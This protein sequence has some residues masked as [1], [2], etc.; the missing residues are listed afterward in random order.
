MTE[1]E[2]LGPLPPKDAVEL[3]PED[4]RD[5][6]VLPVGEEP[7]EG[8]AR[9]PR[10]R[11]AKGYASAVYEDGNT[12]LRSL[13]GDV[14]DHLITQGLAPEDARLTAY[15]DTRHLEATGHVEDSEDAADAIRAREGEPTVGKALTMA[16]NRV[17]PIGLDQG[18]EEWGR[19][20]RENEKATWGE[21]S[22]ALGK[23][24]QG[25]EITEADAKAAGIDLPL[26]QELK[27]AYVSHFGEMV[28]T[29]GSAGI[30]PTIGSITGLI[31]G[32]SDVVEQSGK[33]LEVAKEGKKYVTSEELV[34]IAA[35]GG[36]NSPIGDA[37]PYIVDA[38]VD[39]HDVVTGEDKQGR[40][41]SATGG[42]V[43]DVFWDFVS[44][45]R[46]N[47]KFDPAAKALY[48]EGDVAGLG[49]LGMVDIPEHVPAVKVDLPTLKSAVEAGGLLAEAPEA[50]RFRVGMS[51][52]LSD[53]VLQTLADAIPL[54]VVRRAQ[55]DAG[56]TLKSVLAAYTARKK[57]QE[58]VGTPEAD[59]AL[60][61]AAA[62]LHDREVREDGSVYFVPSTTQK[63]LTAINA[64]VP[65]VIEADVPVLGPVAGVYGGVLKAMGFEKLG[66]MAESARFPTAAGNESMV[67]SG[68]FDWVL[69]GMGLQ[70]STSS[71][72]R[73]DIGE[74]R[75]IDRVLA[76]MQL[77]QYQ[78]WGLKELG[79]DLGVKPGST[80]DVALGT[81]DLGA[82]TVV[83]FEEM[84]LG[85]AGSAV[86][87]ASR[88]ATAAKLSK[89]LGRSNSQ[90]ARVA[91]RAALPQFLGGSTDA[92]AAMDAALRT[93][94]ADSV[95]AGEVLFTVG[96][97]EDAVKGTLSKEVQRAVGNLLEDVGIRKEDVFRTVN[98]LSFAQKA[99][100]TV[101]VKDWMARGT[102]EQ[103]A[104]RET[105]E[106][107]AVRQG[108]EESAPPEVVDAGM[109]LNEWMAH[110][111]V[112]LGEFRSPKDW[113]AAQRV[114]KAIDGAAPPPPRPT[115]VA[116]A[117]R[118]AATDADGE[119]SAMAA[120]LLAMNHP[121]VTSAALDVGVDLGPGVHGR[122][123]IADNHIVL[124]PSATAS[125][126]VHE[127]AHAVTAH[128]LRNVDTLS[129][130]GRKAVADLQ[131]LYAKASESPDLQAVGLGLDNL[132]EFIAEAYSNPA[133]RAALRKVK[134]TPTKSAW[135]VFVDTVGQLLGLKT[136]PELD[137]LDRTLSKIEVVAKERVVP[138][139]GGGSLA[140]RAALVKDPPAPEPPDVLPERHPADT[141]ADV[142]G[143]IGWW[144]PLDEVEFRIGQMAEEH[145]IF[146][147]REGRQIA[148][149]GPEDTR[150]DAPGY[151]PATACIIYPKALDDLAAS[152][153]GVYTHNHPSGSAPSIDDVLVARR[154][155]VDAL[156]AV[157]RNDGFTWVV[158]RPE[159]GWPETDVLRRAWKD[160]AHT[161]Y[162]SAKKRMDARIK[163]AGGNLWEGDRAAGF[164]ETVWKE[165]LTNGYDTHWAE[166]F[167]DL[168]IVLERER[169]PHLGQLGLDAPVRGA[170]GA[171]GAGPAVAGATEA[172]RYPAVGVGEQGRLFSRAAPEGGTV[173]K[174][175]LGSDLPRL[176]D[177]L[178]AS[179][180][181]KPLAEV[182]VK[183]LVQN[184]FDAIKATARTDG[185]IHVT[186]NAQE[187]TLSVADNGKGMTPE[188]VQDALFTV[189][190]TNKEGLAV[191]DRSG[192]L[193]LAKMAFL[194][195]SEWVDVDTVHGGVRTRVHATSAQ[196]KASDFD[197]VTEPAPGAPNG[198]NVTLKIP[199]TYRDPA[200]GADRTIYL[201]K[202]Q[203]TSEQG[204][205]VLDRPL[206]GNVEVLFTEVPRYG[207]PSTAT[208]PVGRNTDPLAT[209]LLTRA[210]FDW[211][212]ADVYMGDARKKYPRHRVLSAG[213][214]QF[215]TA[216]LAGNERIPYDIVVD[217][218]P[219]V[220]PLHPHY[221]FNNQR[222]GW[223]G[224]VEADVKALNGYIAKHSS[225][226]A[227]AETSDVF[228][229]AVTMPRVAPDDLDV[230]AAAP[231]AVKAFAPK[232]PPSP[233]PE[234]AAAPRAPDVIKISAGAVAPSVS[235]RAAPDSFR[236]ERAAPD[237]QS[238]VGSVAVDPLKPLFHN[239]TGVDYIGAVRAALPG[240][241]PERFLA[242]MGSLVLDF[243]EA[244]AKQDK[245]GLADLVSL[246]N[247][248]AAGISIDKDY[249]GVHVK[250]PYRAFFLNPLAATN[251]TASGLAE[252]ML[253]TLVHE[254]A[255]TTVM[256]HNEN[257]ALA[258]A[259]VYDRLGDSGDTDIFRARL[260]KILTR[261]QDTFNEM[262][263]IYDSPRT[264]NLRG[265]LEN[266][267]Q[268]STRGAPG[269]GEGGPGA[270]PGDA[271]AVG[272]LDG[273]AGPA[274]RGV[275]EPSARELIEAALPGLSGHGNAARPGPLY[276]R[277]APAPSAVPKPSLPEP[278]DEVRRAHQALVVKRLLSPSAE[279]RAAHQAYQAEHPEVLAWAEYR[280]A[281]ADAEL[282]QA[283]EAARA[284][285]EAG[286]PARQAAA[287]AKAARYA[288]A[289]ATGKKLPPEERAMNRREWFG[290][291]AVTTT[292]EAGGKPLVVTHESPSKFSE[293]RAGEFGF[294]FGVGIPDGMFGSNRVSGLLRINN[295]MRMADL[296]VWTP[297]RV[298]AEG[299]FSTAEQP[300][301]LA[302]VERIRAEA[303]APTKAMVAKARASGDVA[304][305]E[306]WQALLE[307]G[308]DAATFRDRRGNYLASRPVHDA[309]REKGYDGIVY[310]NEAEGVDDS[311]IAFEPQQFKSNKNVGTYDATDPRFLYSRAAPARAAEEAAEPLP[312]FRSPAATEQRWH[313]IGD[314]HQYTELTIS[315]EGALD[316][317]LPSYAKRGRM[318]SGRGTGFASG[319]YA[320]AD[321]RQGTVPV[322]PARNPLTLRSWG[323]EVPNAAAEF[324][325]D[326]SSLLFLAE[327]LRDLSPAKR[328]EAI[329]LL[330][331]R[332]SSSFEEVYDAEK[333]LA[334]PEFGIG[335]GVFGGEPKFPSD[336]ATALDPLLSRWRRVGV[337]A[338]LD[339]AG[340]VDALIDAAATWGKHQHVHPVNILL[341][342]MGH[343]GIEWA[344]GALKE[345]NTGAHGFVKFPPITADGALV[346]V[347]PDPR[348]GY[349]VTHGGRDPRVLY[350]RA[351]PARAAEYRGVD[352]KP[353]TAT[354]FSGGGLVEAGLR[355]YI[356]PVFAVEVSPEIGAAYKAA[357]GDHVRIDDVRNV[358]LGEA[359]DVDYL[360][361]S[362]VCKN[363]SAAKAVTE[364]GE[365]PLDLETARATA[366]AVHRTQPAVFT[367]ENVR[368]YQ[369][370]EA[371]GLVEAALREEGYTFDANV[372]DA[373]DYGAATRRKRLLLRAVK[374]GDLPPVPAPTH[375]PG[376]AQ[377]YADWY[378][379]VEDLVDDLPDDVVP[380]W[381]RRR[382]EAAGIDPDAPAKPTIV[383]GGSAGKNVP[384]AEAGGP[385]PTFKATPGEAH[386]IIFPDGRVKRVTPRA[387]ARITGLP[388]DYPLPTK[389][390]TATTVIGNGVPPALSEA[391][392]APLLAGDHVP[393][394]LYS[395]AAPIE[396]AA[397]GIVALRKY[398]L[399]A[400]GDDT[401]FDAKVYA[402]RK[403]V[404]ALT[405]HCN[406]A[407]YIVQKR[408]GGELLSAKVDGETHVW[409][410]LADGTEI[411]LTG[412][413]YGGDGFHPVAKNGKV[414]PLRSTVNPRFAAFEDRVAAAELRAA[415]DPRFLY[416]R[417]PGNQTDTPAFQRF[418]EGT[419]AVDE[420]GAPK[421]LYHGT[422]HDFEAF[423]AQS[424]NV[425]NHHGRGIY[426]TSSEGD[427]GS[428]Y[429]TREGP[430]LKSR[431]E[432]QMESLLDV[433][434][435]P[436]VAQDF[437]ERWLEAHPERAAEGE[438]LVQVL[439]DGGNPDAN[440]LQEIT[441]WVAEQEIA[442]SHGGAVLPVYAAIKNPVDLRPGKVTRFDI[443]TKW[444]E[445]GEDF[446]GETG[447]GVEAIDAI[448]RMANSSDTADLI[449]EALGDIS[450][451]FD[452]ADLERAVRD[453][454]IEF[455]DDDS[456]AGQF[457]QDVYRELGFDGIVI[458]A[459]KTFGPRRAGW[460][461]NLPGMAGLTP[462]T[463]H[464]VAFEPTQVKSATGNRGTFDP[465]DKRLLYSRAPDGPTWTAEP[466]PP[467]DKVPGIVDNPAHAAWSKTKRDLAKD[468]AD[469]EDAE[470]S[471]WWEHYGP[472]PDAPTVAP[473]PKNFA[474]AQA[475]WT[476]HGDDPAEF[477]EPSPELSAKLQALDDANAAPE[478][479][480]T[481][482]GLVNDPARVIVR[483]FKTANMQAL[484]EQN[485]QVI[486][487]LLGEKWAGDL[488]RFF[489][490]EVDTASGQ[491]RLTKK[492]EEQFNV[493]LARVLRG[494]LAPR[495]RVRAYFEELRDALSDIWLN[496]RGK[497]MS[498]PPGF[499]QWWD[500]TLD[501]AK[502]LRARVKVSDERFGRQPLEVNVTV[503]ANDPDAPPPPDP[504]RLGREL[505]DVTDVIYREDF[506]RANALH[507]YWNLPL[508]PGQKRHALGILGSD[509]DVDAVEAV[510][511]AIALLGTTQARRRWGFSGKVVRVGRRSQVSEDRK[512]SVLKRA[513]EALHGAI[514]GDVVAA[515]DGGVTLT[516]EQAKG[517]AAHL[518]HLVDAGW[519]E[520]LPDELI[521]PQ[522]DLT[523]LTEQ[524]W[525]DIAN[526]TVD[527]VAGPGSYRDR[528]ADRVVGNAAE[529]LLGRAVDALS[530]VPIFN[531]VR[532]KLT[533]AFDTTF[534]GSKNINPAVAEVVDG[535]RRE[536][537][538]V[539]SQIARLREH[540][541]AGTA[542]E[543]A[544]VLIR[545]IAKE[546]PAVGPDPK[547]VDDLVV[548]NRA[549]NPEGDVTPTVQTFLDN[550]AALRALFDATPAHG[551]A[552]IVEADALP[553]LLRLDATSDIKDPVIAA[554]IEV[555]QT[556]IRRRYEAVRDTGLR[557]EQRMSG[558][559]DLGVA[560]GDPNLP[561]NAY[562][563]WYAGKYQE[564]AA[565]AQR[566]GQTTDPGKSGASG[567]SSDAAGLVFDPVSGALAVV[568][569]LLA[570]GV[571][572]SAAADMMRLGLPVHTDSVNFGGRNFDQWVPLGSTSMSRAKYRALVQEYMN[573]ILSF[574]GSQSKQFNEAREFV[575]TEMLP[576]QVSGLNDGKF[577]P[578][579]WADAHRILDS[580]G[581][582]SNTSGMETMVLPTGEE[583][584]MPKIIKDELTGLF[585]RTAKA[586]L[587][588]TKSAE[589]EP[590]K[591]LG[592]F[593]EFVDGRL[594]PNNN[595][596][597]KGKGSLADNVNIAVRTMV[598]IPGRTL[599]MAR[600]GVTTGVGIPNPAFYIG[601]VFGG[602]LQAVQSK[603]AVGTARMLGR[604][605]PG[606]G[607][608]AGKVLRSVFCRVWGDSQGYFKPASGSF[609]ADNGAVI[610]DD[611][612]TKTV[613]K[614]GL[615]TSQPRAESAIR[616]IDDLRNHEGT[617]W[618][619]VKR[620]R[621]FDVPLLG[622]AESAV[623]TGVSTTF[624]YWQGI[625]GDAATAVDDLF[626]V[627]TYVD[628]LA[629]GVAPAEAAAVARRTSFDYADL[630]DFEKE[631]LRRFIMFYTFQRRN[632]DLFWWTMLNH[633]SRIMGQVRAVRDAQEHF[634]GEDDS[635]SI[636]PEH[637]DGRLIIG[638]RKTLGDEAALRG[639]LG[640]MTVAPPLPAMDHL[641]LWVSIF[642]SLNSDEPRGG[643]EIISRLAPEYQAPFVLGL[644]VDIF[645]GRDLAAFNTV[646]SWMVEMDRQISGGAMVDDLF[647][648]R[649]TENSD[650]SRDEAPGV[651]RWEPTGEGAKWWWVFR[652]LVQV[653]PFGRGTDTITQMA[654]ADWIVGDVVNGARWYRAT[655]GPVGAIR[656]N[657]T[658]PFFRSVVRP[659]MD[660]LPHV[661]PSAVQVYE[662][663]A[664]VEDLNIER[665]GYTPGLEAAQLFG[666]KSVIV[667]TAAI[668]A[669]ED[670]V[671]R[672][673]RISTAASEERKRDPYR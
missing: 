178:G 411:D 372:Y 530:T 42:T 197:I 479:S 556:G 316:P 93:A 622:T 374:D 552:G 464:W 250:V 631:H 346:D 650:P 656:D 64:A 526:T 459:Y 263:R 590:D 567:S 238:F 511:K 416:S 383:M 75:Y 363:F 37:I 533:E 528:Q 79:R 302:E 433:W 550:K 164:S 163:A 452:A 338:G 78:N 337:P 251:E 230:G 324:Q 257:F 247:P 328:A 541:R 165:Y 663:P 520:Q 643:R 287:D 254:V 508:T 142:R 138:G 206:F 413:Q 264:S 566:R 565:Q 494:D 68:D 651:D 401:A 235:E 595:L 658:D 525:S 502:H 43:G 195:G 463:E 94:V 150:R 216:I 141:W 151:D 154:G 217:I 371:M 442:G 377:P 107:K 243:K 5:P 293:F 633:P 376:R 653:P 573:A 407:A 207:T 245:Y 80:A 626:R 156:R 202:E 483:Y 255:H 456:S 139:R 609:I 146:F 436:S 41:R 362:P 523:K 594:Y 84:F 521:S 627:A 639:S 281:V 169:H 360:H 248:Y 390:A 417:A 642:R 313:R 546:L 431:I 225:G 214:H 558:R 667:P 575:G 25:E 597:Y 393:G 672:R 267:E 189:G 10:G 647:K 70:G 23:A 666:V 385:A 284:E 568:T 405:G 176:L 184:A 531:G 428:N 466:P 584:F 598:N 108:L 625:L 387:A 110:Q 272:G 187:R 491:V 389:N 134:V 69:E 233:P 654:R 289:K 166:Y 73:R 271:A 228:K 71:E 485:A 600:V 539:A 400:A 593:G 359:G 592:R 159:A 579:A 422:T 357:H 229:G 99:K 537:S 415:R 559:A 648:V 112:V 16:V 620:D 32:W 183:E 618:T 470:L 67:A 1:D 443:E 308:S 126:L 210:A 160:L 19:R 9:T 634:L 364:S 131:A 86:T 551:P 535:W 603:G 375:G 106:W 439:D 391:V 297:E 305:A 614:Y 277:A 370:T 604:Y 129:P 268:L 501:P 467:G 65:L 177:L 212:S 488:M 227:A 28:Y 234:G 123:D 211:G 365:Q 149:F 125:T 224:T 118:A 122:Y 542:D 39:F 503:K 356:D 645:S 185:Q 54:D 350:S 22:D 397:P 52:G 104:L 310:R 246:E 83:P 605:L 334:S 486:R 26:V 12:A 472:S 487:M 209:P 231:A 368:G 317:S 430:D 669:D 353:R 571:L 476:E 610:S 652:N 213:L 671:G 63:V 471:A 480:R 241:E 147:D 624:R 51:S 162:L 540:V 290:D 386:R 11:I 306:K 295:P 105:A 144:M 437:V 76:D 641:G 424:G 474:E 495:G 48:E 8:G 236:P 668:A 205:G 157:A 179:M 322:L 345:G 18:P 419:K 269:P 562:K 572:A 615:H 92:V 351:A 340:T 646:P 101:I 296:G 303:D 192:G 518:D 56:P 98:D 665:A 563:L 283:R 137:A 196:I 339:G 119:V 258:L 355:K 398:M 399:D 404:C 50:D 304:T 606:V 588:W 262:R 74:S 87:M 155:N 111:A 451:G 418:I 636:L 15:E 478:P 388:D 348:H 239:N 513:R 46:H 82:D 596:Q 468:V 174:G 366:D 403:Q 577:D 279:T 321:A 282:A 223:R 186:L 242:E 45:G 549:L 286:A 381:M 561:I 661:D 557:I 31:P 638:M 602:L 299:G 7:P 492:G 529:S 96:R 21:R 20:V 237:L 512:E 493:A 429:A 120:R 89:M 221:P 325:R 320:F 36:V 53:E 133:F 49:Q 580:W 619:R 352:G 121:A 34:K 547:V 314:D 354:M 560:T 659:M 188:V 171:P 347:V 477:P 161:V 630:T 100:N 252:S 582:K 58:I 589:G 81:A 616:I 102:P 61:V 570:D 148:R 536:F 270:A 662:P 440:L 274:R 554:A 208:L 585:D 35:Y 655:Q 90:A 315:P 59:D 191:G 6:E 27:K 505:A 14:A 336:L 500:A 115:T 489:D 629:G 291:S 576:V 199:E 612:I 198:T 103:K 524:E 222:E 204:S 116:D 329:D 30:L 506:K 586:G 644:E 319:M 219:G 635:E 145:A 301:L 367:L 349:A 140:S 249:R 380:P 373:A 409:N 266:G 40:L 382:L 408:Y 152:G 344:G 444:S 44:K 113:F 117:L 285:Y 276:S 331:A 608:D 215:D 534:A 574:Q 450:E 327:R 232:A 33:N 449:I 432:S 475:Y 168:G 581:I 426:L 261:H 664:I 181:S 420:D 384:Y 253:H 507:E 435:D 660:A 519:G 601:N 244:A 657:L 460:G 438:R 510:A 617:F 544:E 515:P 587:P 379:A 412:S 24:L 66:G 2:V 496:L 361:A 447:A 60:K 410:R 124:S 4:Y 91:V 527:D 341:S 201:F 193:G 555:I 256:A 109:A 395:R 97:G 498:L 504:T 294:H 632:A 423:D 517:L 649:K 194:F 497:P 292:G 342:R 469:L 312:V 200:S 280:A 218:R 394:T 167:G 611:F 55:P 135:R 3:A 300:R 406:A 553:R 473:R 414:V 298:L 38:A 425:E 545:K 85:P 323:L 13:R 628:E 278:T 77:P 173:R 578:S 130:A 307:D 369:G 484:L 613:V 95:A 275:G 288:D 170:A 465:K 309:L 591:I 457:L 427:V 182:A 332:V 543:T 127:V 623:R 583:V 481:T 421:R 514:G 172:A 226:R 499:R 88:A 220:D 311:Y 114:G 318:S 396:D 72:R 516:P 330:R 509:T 461:V 128:A 265:A 446:L 599:A 453:N 260:R 402:E 607:G 175:R 378:A 57:I 240:A 490:H 637:L 333:R 158:R 17:T 203:M 153:G 448:R 564:L 462:G 532:R 343:D 548:L 136:K 445:D 454:S 62:A 47:E 538:D 29:A 259:D 640:T 180:Y 673:R 482:A 458:D 441:R 273:D 434:D 670:E 335:R 522:K 392:F 455:L 621:I 326:A 569:G 358:D 132:D 143:P 190:G